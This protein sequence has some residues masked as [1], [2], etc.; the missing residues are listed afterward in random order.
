M[1]IKQDI[2]MTRKP[3]EIEQKYKLGEISTTEKR[4]TELEDN[5][6]VDT[7]LS[8]SS[9]RPV[10]NKII[11]E[12]LNK[13][14]N[15]IPGKTLTTNDFTDSYKTKLEGIE[16]NANNYTQPIG[17]VFFSVNQITDTDWSYIDSITIG[18]ETVY[19]Y[20]KIS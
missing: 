9:L 3:T 6:T 19:C 5:M 4:V 14:A 15:A 20:K 18:S 13:K 17:S 16:D 7:E 8:S 1:N 11:T 10:A 12:T 2:S